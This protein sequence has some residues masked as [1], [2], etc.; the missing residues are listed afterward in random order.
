MI[1]VKALPMV[2]A[3]GH[4]VGDEMISEVRVRRR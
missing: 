3:N 4:G 2:T 1:K